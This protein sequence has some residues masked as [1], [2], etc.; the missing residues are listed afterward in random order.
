[1]LFGIKYC[2]SMSPDSRAAF[3]SL[4]R[5]ALQGLAADHPWSIRKRMSGGDIAVIDGEPESS[6][7]DAE[8]SGGIGQVHPG[9]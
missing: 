4:S 7:T 3:Q 5:F 1:M 2:G 8:Q 9:S 6:R